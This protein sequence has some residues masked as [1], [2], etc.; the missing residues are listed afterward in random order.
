[1]RD[2]AYSLIARNRFRLGGKYEVC[3]LPTA[4]DREKFMGITD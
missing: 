2:A 4:E 1:V 3:P